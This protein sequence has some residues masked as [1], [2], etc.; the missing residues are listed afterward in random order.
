M[1]ANRNALIRYKTIDACLRNQWFAVRVRKENGS[2][3]SLALDRIVEV[4]LSNDVKYVER[5]DELSG[6]RNS[7][8]KIKNSK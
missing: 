5:N 3:S 1:L 8:F 7:L 4:S 2:L 6:V